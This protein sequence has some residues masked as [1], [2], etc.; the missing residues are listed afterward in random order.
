MSHA[1]ALVGAPP[2]SG[3]DFWRI[4]DALMSMFD[5]HAGAVQPHVDV[6]ND[7]AALERGLP[8]DGPVANSAPRTTT[9]VV[10]GRESGDPVS[11]ARGKR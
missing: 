10:Q 9:S 7:G 2:A 1:G 11:A 5:E 3:G 4:A 8:L 6:E